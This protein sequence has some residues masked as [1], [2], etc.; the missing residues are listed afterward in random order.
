MPIGILLCEHFL[1][2][3][4]S[5]GERFRRDSPQTANEPGAVNRSDLIQDD[6]SFRLLELT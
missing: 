2:D 4:R 6:E 1:E 3:E 5:V